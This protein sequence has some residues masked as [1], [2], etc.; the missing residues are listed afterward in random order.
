MKTTSRTYVNKNNPKPQLRK[1][2]DRIMSCLIIVYNSCAMMIWRGTKRHP[3]HHWRTC[4]R[5]DYIYMTIYQ[6]GSGSPSLTSFQTD[7]NWVKPALLIYTSL[8]RGIILSNGIVNYEECLAPSQWDVDPE[9]S[10]SAAIFSQRDWTS[11]GFYPT[12]D[13][14]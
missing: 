12:A 11:N 3:F 14:R 9:L 6:S 10:L 5:T 1:C 4:T 8:V 13:C 2:N 7:T